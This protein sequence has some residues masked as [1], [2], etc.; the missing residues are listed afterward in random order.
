M[1]IYTLD[2]TRTMK[3][4]RTFRDGHR[5]NWWAL[6]VEAGPYGKERAQRALVLGP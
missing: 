1:A 6:E 4:I 2:R 5:E 3:M